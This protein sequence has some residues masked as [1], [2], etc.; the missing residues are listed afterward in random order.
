[1]IVDV[2]PVLLVANPLGSTAMSH[3]PMVPQVCAAAAALVTQPMDVVKTR[4]QETLGVVGP[5]FSCRVTR[6]HWV[7][8]TPKVADFHCC[9][10]N[11][12]SMKVAENIIDLCFF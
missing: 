9:K 11:E 3:D 10:I 6:R 4:M 5:T 12:K 1:M 7:A 2:F 8:T